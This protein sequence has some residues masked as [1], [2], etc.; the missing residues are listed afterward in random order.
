VANERHQ[1]VLD[2]GHNIGFVREGNES[3]QPSRY[4]GRVLALQVLKAMLV[5]RCDLKPRTDFTDCID[6]HEHEL[7]TRLHDCRTEYVAYENYQQT[8]TG[9]LRSANQFCVAA[10]CL[11]PLLD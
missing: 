8:S 9:P 6:E 7:I 11:Q 2:S 5:L 1:R 10:K 4:P 3:V